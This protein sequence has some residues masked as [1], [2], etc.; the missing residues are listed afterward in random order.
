MIDKL[1]ELRGVKIGQR[2]TKRDPE[3]GRETTFDVTGFQRGPGRLVRVQGRDIRTGKHLRVTLAS[4]ASGHG[5]R[6][7]RDAGAVA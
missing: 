1:T 3:G 2:W 4:F 6:L 5:L 7:V